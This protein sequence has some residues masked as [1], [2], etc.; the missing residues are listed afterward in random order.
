VTGARAQSEVYGR[1]EIVRKSIPGTLKGR[2][3]FAREN[4]MGSFSEE[5]WEVPAGVRRESQQKHDPPEN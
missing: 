3:A 2:K 5:M 4:S 1:N